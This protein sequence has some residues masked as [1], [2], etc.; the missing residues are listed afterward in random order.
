MHFDVF[1]EDQS[2]GIAIDV[3]LRKILKSLSG[4]HNFSIYPYKG[5]GKIPSDLKPKH[6]PKKRILLDSLPKILRGAW[7]RY[8]SD[9]DNYAMI[10]VVDLD[11]R[12][13]KKFKKELLDMSNKI[14]SAIPHPPKVLFRIAIEEIE[15]WLLG[16]ISAVKMA[17]PNAKNAVL[18]RYKQDSICGTWEVLADAIYEGGSTNLKKAGLIGNAKCEWAK[19]ISNHMSIDDNK[20]KSFQVF[21]DGIRQLVDN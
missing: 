18:N 16:D 14:Y 9:L 6:D 8:H 11:D 4:N 12:D 1:V 20:S 2:G 13:C 3:I 5:I 10:V 17:Y 19:E 7:R 15:S 21:R